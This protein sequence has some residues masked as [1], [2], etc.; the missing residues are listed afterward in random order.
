[1]LDRAAIETPEASGLSYRQTSSRALRE[2]RCDS[3]FP[4]RNPLTVHKHPL[5][6]GCNSADNVTHAGAG[7]CVAIR[8]AV[9]AR[10]KEQP[11]E[12]SGHSVSEL[13]QMALKTASSIVIWRRISKGISVG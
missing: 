2:F 8:L 13:C 12:L 1:V 11:S 4:V 10:R 5:T 7:R 6:Q 9:S 3:T